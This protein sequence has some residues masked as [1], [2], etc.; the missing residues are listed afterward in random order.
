[1]MA[2][3]SISLSGHDR[4]QEVPLRGE[5]ATLGR[6]ASCEVCIRHPSLSRRHAFLQLRDGRWL[7][8]DLGS[9]N[10]TTLNG[11]RI[12][13]KRILHHRD[14]IQIGKVSVHFMDPDHQVVE[15]RPDLRPTE[16]QPKPAD[17]DA[18]NGGSAFETGG[19]RTTFDGDD[20]SLFDEDLAFDGPPPAPPAAI[21]AA[22]TET[23]QAATGTSDNIELDRQDFDE[24]FC[25]GAPSMDDLLSDSVDNAQPAV[26]PPKPKHDT[27]RRGDDLD[28]FDE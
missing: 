23:E 5:A 2:N 10:G 21:A 15:S 11:R 13:D 9:T 27:P 22:D 18:D 14:L 7:V 16:R 20:S 12:D 4:V 6:D 1:M 24:L 17:T 25:N 19:M 26:T 8:E 3:L 28:F